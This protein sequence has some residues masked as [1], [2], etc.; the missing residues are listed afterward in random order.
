MRIVEGKVVGGFNL[1]AVSVHRLCGGS[2]CLGY[3]LGLHIFNLRFSFDFDGLRRYIGVV[4]IYVE[5]AAQ[6]LAEYPS[7]IFRYVLNPSVVAEYD[8]RFAVRVGADLAFSAYHMTGIFYEVAVVDN[9]GSLIFDRYDKLFLDGA[10]RLFTCMF[11]QHN[12]VTADLGVGG[13]G[14]GVVGKSYS[15]DKVGAF[16]Q[17]YTHMGRRGVHY[18]LRGYERHDTAL[19]HRVK[20]F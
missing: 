18:A 8:C 1:A 5:I 9:L 12:Q 15:G 16:H 7:Q 14:K 13:V 2:L 4:E 10:Q 20:S 6:C 17:L 3:Y 11:L 19:T